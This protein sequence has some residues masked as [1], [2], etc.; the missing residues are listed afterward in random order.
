MV[1][2]DIHRQVQDNMVKRM[3]LF[4]CSNRRDDVASSPIAAS[5]VAAS[6]D[7]KLVRWSRFHGC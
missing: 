3:E 4:G 2:F 5:L 7:E 6:P 1:N